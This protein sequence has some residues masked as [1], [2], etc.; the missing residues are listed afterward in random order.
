MMAGGVRWRFRAPVVSALVAMRRVAVIFVIALAA[1]APLVAQDG[2]GRLSTDRTP[3]PVTGLRTPVVL[4]PG[5]SD[6]SETLEPLR[7]RFL[8]AGW[9]PMAI[10]VVA[11]E[12]PVGSNHDHA[13]E[14]DAA[15]DRLR[16]RTGNGS[17]D[18]VAHSMG[19]LATRLFLQEG[20]R[21]E[22]R[23]AV[24]VATPHRGTW[25]AMLA[26]GDGGEEMKPGSPFLLEL[27]NVRG[28]PPGVEALTIRSKV[29]LHILPPESATLNGVPDVE[30]C[31]PSHE[32]LLNHPQAFDAMARF[33]LRAP[34]ASSSADGSGS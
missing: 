11:F 14:L 10:E 27:R 19:G 17:V 3:L 29:D 24:F 31:C 22:V 12:D 26:W 21:E 32:G 20:G 28:V 4:V 2:A 6:D 23:R 30:I 1:A 7:E 34:T 5:W 18:V 13:E 16:E 33:L 25:L 15:V 9:S 8:A